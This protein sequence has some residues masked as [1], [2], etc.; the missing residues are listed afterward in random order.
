LVLQTTG[1]TTIGS[2]Q[3]TNIASTVGLAIGQGVFMAGVPSYSTVTNIL[4]STVTIGYPA[5]ATS[6]GTTVMFAGNTLYG[7][8]PD[9]PP[10]ATLNE[11]ALTSL[12]R[13]SNVVTATTTNPHNYQVGD[14]VAIYG[15][16]GI[17][18]QTS[19]GAITI[20]TPTMTGV[21][22]VGTA[23]PGE[24]IIGANIPLGTLIENVVGTT[25][26]MTESATGSGS[27]VVTFN[28]NLNGSFIITSVSSNTFTYD[29][30]GL[31]GTASTPGGSRVD[32]VG[33]APSGSLVLI[34]AA[35]PVS[36]T[37][38][39]GPYVWDLAAPFVLS[40]NIATIVG[41]IQ[42]GQSITVLNLSTNTIP[43]DGGFVIFDYGLN[44]QEG[45]IR[46]LYAPNNTAI[47]IDPSYIFEHNHANGSN[48]IAI[49]NKGPHI[50]S[51]LGTEYPPYITNPGDVLVTL[52]KLIESVTSAGI[53]VDFLVRY[54]D[55]L[56]SVLPTY[57]VISNS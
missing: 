35:L 43:L 24:L 27:E 53:F 26:T 38:I 20:G 32:T 29:S 55:Q 19:N 49:D 13:S 10:L 15:S 4:G 51:G 41:N 46:Y 30:I 7:I 5:T 57:T 50:M 54:P 31:N 12:T 36:F 52:E 48:I 42:A 9:L 2:N 40:E 33:M 22:P 34:T 56:Y 11:N 44:T 17:V 18:S 47:I 16:N 39:T 1:D 37:R 8:T 25:I 6:I 14:I 23:A 21:S 28:E 45:P 3:I